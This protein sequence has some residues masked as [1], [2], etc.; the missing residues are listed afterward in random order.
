MPRYDFV[1]VSS[2]NRSDPVLTGLIGTRAGWKS[3]ERG[4]VE[5]GAWSEEAEDGASSGDFDVGNFYVVLCG[6]SRVGRGMG[7]SKVFTRVRGGREKSRNAHRHL[8][9]YDSRE[10]YTLGV[11]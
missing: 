8:S 11:N 9:D 10:G 5:R 2:P 4:S 1:V 6:L 7:G 3:G